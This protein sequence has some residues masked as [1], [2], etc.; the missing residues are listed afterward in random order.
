MGNEGLYEVIEKVVEFVED[1]IKT[2]I[3]HD[4]LAKEVHFS[5]YHLQRLFKSVT[6][7]NLMKYVRARQLAMSLE[8]L[9]KTDLRINDIAEEFG[10]DYYQSYIRAFKTEYGFT[11]AE[12][13][14]KKLA[15]KI[16]DKFD[17]T[18]VKA[19]EKGVIFEPKI[20]IK[21][22]FYVVGIKNKVEK[23]ENLKTQ[24][25]NKLAVDF[26]YNHRKKIKNKKYEYEYIGLTF[27]IDEKR[28]W[29]Y[30]ITGTEVKNLTEVPEKMVGIKIPPHR[31]IV[32]K[33][34]GMHPP[35]EVSSKTLKQMWEYIYGTWM[36]NVEYKKCREM[37]FERM[38]V[39]K[40]DKNYCEVNIYYPL[41]EI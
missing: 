18:N 10:F 25:S 40:I 12:F 27:Q 16:V 8:E 13:R 31:Y 23:K 28:E 33:Y 38:C 19:L 36:S 21:P 30:Y 34:V 37:H 11:P 24:I 15:V 9:I 41:E 29:S 3:T 26:Y 1:N 20:V 6:G 39:D 7:H 14:K 4:M 35:E 32:F 22:E 17:I 5:K 2:K